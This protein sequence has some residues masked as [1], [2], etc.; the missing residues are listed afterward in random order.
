MKIL[1]IIISIS[2]ILLALKLLVELYKVLK[3]KK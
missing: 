2:L 3:T 1:L